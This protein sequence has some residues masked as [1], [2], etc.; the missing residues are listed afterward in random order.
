MNVVF[1]LTSDPGELAELLDYSARS[2][3]DYVDATIALVSSEMRFERQNLRL[4]VQAERL[5]VTLLIEGAPID[6]A[7]LQSDLH[8][9]WIESSRCHHLGHVSRSGCQRIAV[10]GETPSARRLYPLGRSR[11]QPLPIRCGLAAGPRPSPMKRGTHCRA[12]FSSLRMANGIAK[13]AS[14]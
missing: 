3:F 4:D 8:T 10:S 14:P 5:T 2:I 6:T 9:R 12:V 13:P 11:S 7:W 1:T